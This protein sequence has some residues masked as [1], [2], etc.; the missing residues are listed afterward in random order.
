MRAKQASPYNRIVIDQ[1]R[2]SE[3]EAYRTIR[4]NIQYSKI[5]HEIKTILITSTTPGEGK[6]VT[7]T[8]LACAMAHADMKTLYIDADLRKPTGHNVFG[9]SNRYGLTSLLAGRNQ[10]AEVL[11]TTAYPGLSAITSGP[12]PPN[13]AELLGSNRMKGILQQLRE[14]FDI[15]IIDSPPVLAVADPIVLG[16]QTDGCVL[17]LDTAMTKRDAALTAKMKL[18]KVN[19]RMLGVVINNKKEKAKSCNYYYEN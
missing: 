10:L 4:A 17:V 19:A 7:A 9:L 2:S 5:D 11:Q 16:A 12:I 18:D 15:V 3:F 6:T 14:V 1:P 13:P 8:N